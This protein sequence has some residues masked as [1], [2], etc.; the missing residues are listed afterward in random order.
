MGGDCGW[1]RQGQGRRETCRTI[2]IPAE[3]EGLVV[4]VSSV[5]CLLGRWKERS[6]KRGEDLVE[7]ELRR[8]PVGRQGRTWVGAA[9]SIEMGGSRN[10]KAGPGRPAPPTPPRCP[11]HPGIGW[12]GGGWG[13]DT[14]FRCVTA[15]V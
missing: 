9:Q 15:A 10:Q 14:G 6:G 13:G 11:S 2:C 4:I 8:A 5:S 1:V 3:V 12:R 7:E